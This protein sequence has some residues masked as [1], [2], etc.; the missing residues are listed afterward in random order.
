MI[1]P[2]LTG[3]AVLVAGALAAGTQIL[4]VSTASAAPA[5]VP[6][7][8]TAGLW[9]SANASGAISLSKSILMTNGLVHSEGGITI[10]HTKGNLSGGTEYVTTLSKDTKIKIGPAAVQVAPASADPVTPTI[11]DY[12]PGGAAALAASSYTAIDPTQCVGGWWTPSRTATFTGVVYVPCGVSLTGSKPRTIPATIAAEGT[13]MI[14]SQKITIGQGASAPALVSG[15][16]GDTGVLFDH[17]K[18]TVNGMVL[19]PLGGVRITHAAV[20][21]SCGAE[22]KTIT[23]IQAA[24]KVPRL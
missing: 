13:I 8:N 7:W 21:L 10:H 1:I 20:V 18:S 3:V 5:P 15:T 24:I 22:A 17:S 6:I 9:A 4:A 16:V 2:R 23:A 11:A 14:Q 19:A 12:R